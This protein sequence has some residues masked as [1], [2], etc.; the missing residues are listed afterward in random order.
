MIDVVTVFAPRPEHPQWRDYMPLLRLQRDSAQHFGHRH[1]MVTDEPEDMREF[2]SFAVTLPQSLM[3]AQLAGQVAYL[4]QWSG[5]HPAVFVDADCLIT[6][7]LD[8]AFDGTFD[9]GLTHR[10][11]P[12]SRINN[13][14]MYVAPGNRYGVLAFFRAALAICGEHWGGDQEAI[15]AMAAPVPKISLD[16]ETRKRAPTIV[17]SRNALRLGFLNGLD[18][19]VSPKEEGVRHARNPFVV[20]FKGETKAWMKTYYERFIRGAR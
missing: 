17:E 14:A 15:S 4:D 16:K 3:L 13:G 12:T 5:D 6:R 20:H 19:N 10:D 7:A 1:V 11:D 2:E 18:Y 8:E 9:L